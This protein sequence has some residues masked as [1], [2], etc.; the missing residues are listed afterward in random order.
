MS[1]AAPPQTARQS[2]SITKTYQHSERKPVLFRAVVEE[3]GSYRKSRYLVPV[4]SFDFAA[5]RR[6]ASL[7]PY[8]QSGGALDGML[9]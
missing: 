7:T 2:Q 5:K 4:A 3:S 6:A 9:L 8:P 1:K